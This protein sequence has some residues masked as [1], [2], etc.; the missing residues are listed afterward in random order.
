ML[1]ALK[2][3]T[4]PL[5]KWLALIFIVI[6]LPTGTY[7]T[8]YKSGVNK[9]KVVEVKKEDKAEEIVLNKNAVIQGIADTNTMA[10]V[11]YKDRVE[12]KYKTIN[13]YI[14]TYAKT[15]AANTILDPMFVR[16]HDH[17]ASPVPDSDTVTGSTGGINGDSTSSEPTSTN[18]SVT[19][20]QA[21][22][23]ITDNYKEYNICREKVIKWSAFYSGIKSQVNK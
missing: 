13:N 15:P 20:G 2:F 6:A 5:F 8:G 23:V 7:Y 9:E 10:L 16:L 21:I 22:E 19:T 18:P 3:V 17:A 11:V 12:T 1:M 14:T 4:S